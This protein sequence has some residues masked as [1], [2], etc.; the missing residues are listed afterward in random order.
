MSKIAKVDDHSTL[1]EEEQVV[2]L[3][4]KNGGRLTDG[5]E[6]SLSVLRMPMAAGRPTGAIRQDQIQQTESEA[7]VPEVESPER[8]ALAAS[9]TDS[10]R[11]RGNFI[12]EQH[13]D[14]IILTIVQEADIFGIYLSNS[15]TILSVP[16]FAD[17]AGVVLSNPS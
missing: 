8:S 11:R 9:C 14:N 15:I 1:S 13:P 17:A 3:R 16:R 10:V 5:S 12:P 6:N 4:E 2:E 7:P